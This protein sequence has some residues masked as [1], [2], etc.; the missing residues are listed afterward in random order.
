MTTEFER[1]RETADGALAGRDV[2]RLVV[3]ELNDPPAGD[4]EQRPYAELARWREVNGPDIPIP[5]LDRTERD[6]FETVARVFRLLVERPERTILAILHGYVVTWISS[7]AG[8]AERGGNAEEFTMTAPELL[9]A[10]DAA[11]GDVFRHWSWETSGGRSC[12][13]STRATDPLRGASSVRRFQRREHRT[14]LPDRRAVERV[15]DLGA[16]PLRRDDAGLP[17]DAQVLA[18]RRLADVE[19]VGEIARARARLPCEPHRDAEAHGVT[20]RLQAV[21]I[22]GNISRH[23]A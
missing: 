21:R 13:E 15:A 7:C 23:L 10:L 22:G 5:G 3:P 1:T 17:Q 2:P 19:D 11:A 4:L 16:A 14:D 20:E 12:S 6:Y 8:A 18:D 9:D